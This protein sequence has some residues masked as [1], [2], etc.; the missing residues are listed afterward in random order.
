MS[1]SQG[2]QF[3][4]VCSSALVNA[5]AYQCY[6]APNRTSFQLSTDVSFVE[7]ALLEVEIELKQ[8]RYKG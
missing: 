1:D 4:K 2:C 6:D 5:A 7:K 3:Q 8:C